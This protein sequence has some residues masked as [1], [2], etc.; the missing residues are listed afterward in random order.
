MLIQEPL[1]ADEGLVDGL[2]VA[3]VLDGVVEGF[4]VFE[5]EEGG[6]FGGIEFFDSGLDVVGEDEFEEG[7]LFA[8]ELAADGEAGAGGA[9]FPSEGG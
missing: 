4:S 7:L 5:S 3:Q 1:E 2:G 6:E 9:F 8:V